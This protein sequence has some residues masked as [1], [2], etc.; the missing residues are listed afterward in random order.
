MYT[1]IDIY[2]YTCIHSSNILSLFLSLS[3]S[4]L[5]SRLTKLQYKALEYA[6]VRFQATGLSG[7]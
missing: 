7:V 5:S 3:L 2:M 1:Y 6:V 4:Q